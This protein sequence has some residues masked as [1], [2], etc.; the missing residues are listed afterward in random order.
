MELRPTDLDRAALD[1]ITLFGYKGSHC[2]GKS[3][4]QRMTRC[5]VESEEPRV[6]QSVP[7]LLDGVRPRKLESASRQRSRGESEKGGV[8]FDV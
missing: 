7:K 3:C 2:I 8:S 4:R 1:E 6:A 5:T